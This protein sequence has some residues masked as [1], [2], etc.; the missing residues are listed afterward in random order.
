MSPETEDT[1]GIRC[2]ILI[3]NVKNYLMRLDGQYSCEECLTI[4]F[5]HKRKRGHY[6]QYTYAE[7]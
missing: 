7:R 3:L 1:C 6:E 4:I 5:F 2:L